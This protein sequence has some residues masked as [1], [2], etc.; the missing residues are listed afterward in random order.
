[1]PST[2][3]PSFI[4][5]GGRGRRR[6]G[7]GGGTSPPRERARMLQVGE[8]NGGEGRPMDRTPDPYRFFYCTTMVCLVT[9][10]KYSLVTT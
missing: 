5:D 7:G 2:R 1:M 3:E 4:V 10:D 6:G 8:G 9:V